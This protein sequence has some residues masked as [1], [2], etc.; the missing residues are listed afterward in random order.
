MF[1]EPVASFSQRLL[2]DLPVCGCF[3]LFRP[4]NDRIRIRIGLKLLFREEGRLWPGRWT[5]IRHTRQEE[6]MLDTPMLAVVARSCSLNPESFGP[7]NLLA[8]EHK[9]RRMK[10]SVT[11]QGECVKGLYVTG[12]YFYVSCLRWRCSLDSWPAGPSARCL[13]NEM[14]SVF[15]LRIV[16]SVRH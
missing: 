11:S 14:R 6:G 1:S 3:L 9:N 16:A 15:I 12:D 7:L 8:D 13:W 2:V 5:P 10:C 4:L